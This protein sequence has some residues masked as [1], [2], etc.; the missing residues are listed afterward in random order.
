MQSCKTYLICFFFCLFIFVWF[1]LFFCFDLVQFGLILFWF[2]VF[3]IFLSYWFSDLSSRI[4]RKNYY[5]NPVKREKSTVLRR[6]IIQSKCYGTQRRFYV[7]KLENFSSKAVINCE[8]SQ[9]QKTTWIKRGKIL[10]A[11]EFAYS[12]NYLLS[13]LSDFCCI[14]YY[15]SYTSLLWYISL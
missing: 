4:S 6:G 5:V 11:V 7:S 8:K 12:N 1:G 3:G 14:F 9:I 10:K 15:S 13:Q 2:F